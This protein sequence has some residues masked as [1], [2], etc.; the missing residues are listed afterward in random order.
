MDVA[1]FPKRGET[2]IPQH[3]AY[4][5]DRF[6]PGMASKPMNRT[7]Y[8]GNNMRDSFRDSSSSPVR[9]PLRDEAHFNSPYT[10]GHTL[11]KMYQTM[12]HMKSG[13]TE[14]KTSNNKHLPCKF[15]VAGSIFSDP[16]NDLIERQRM[17]KTSLETEA[18]IAHRRIHFNA[19]AFS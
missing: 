7:V 6:Y 19:S 18:E 11:G 9:D 14:R 12:Q 3:E 17:N 2:N 13:K 15:N 4:T 1:W 16:R 10:K 8:F 5:G